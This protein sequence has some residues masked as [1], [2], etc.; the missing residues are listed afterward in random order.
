MQSKLTAILH[1]PFH[2]VPLA[3][4]ITDNFHSHDINRYHTSNYLVLVTNATA[5]AGVNLD[6]FL[7][8]TTQVY[9]LKAFMYIKLHIKPSNTN[10]D[11]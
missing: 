5:Q 8:A 9:Y 1:V 10:N 7:F 2:L 3:Y 11:E 6:N 4:L